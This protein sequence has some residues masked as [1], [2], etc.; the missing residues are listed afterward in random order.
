M[1]KNDEKEKLNENK[2]DIEETNQKKNHRHIY[3]KGNNITF[4]IKLHAKIYIVSGD[5]L[6]ISDLN[7][8][9]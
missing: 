6:H 8:L 2:K 4:A 5:H 7:F 3:F 9:I 1:F